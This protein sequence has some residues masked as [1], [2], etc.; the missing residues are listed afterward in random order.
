M[1]LRRIKTKLNKLEIPSELRTALR[2]ADIFEAIENFRQ[3]EYYYFITIKGNHLESEHLE[4]L[5]DFDFD[6]KVM[7]EENKLIICV[8]K[9][10][11]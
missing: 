3:D 11:D 10:L 7:V 4:I 9:D 6:F 1:S 8:Y 2:E 5:A